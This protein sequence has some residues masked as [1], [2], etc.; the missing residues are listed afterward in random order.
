MGLSA[1]PD[2]GDNGIHASA[3]PFEGLAERLNW[4][5]AQLETDTFGK[6][7]LAAGVPTETIM[8]YTQ[9]PQVSFDGEMTSLFDLLED[10]DADEC[11]EKAAKAEMPE[12]VKT[13]APA[14]VKAPAPAVEAAEEA[15]A[16]APA[17]VPVPAAAAAE[18][19]SSS[20]AGSGT[21]SLEEITSSSLPED[22]DSANKELSLH[23][24]KFQELFGM[25][26]EAFQKLPQWKR[27]NL[28][29][30]HGLF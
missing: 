18:S 16:P 30:K 14:V 13:P 1:Q 28:K 26:K 3:S 8:A 20:G 12:V 24:D 10:T 5:G 29:K 6:K 19:S 9:D 4:C 2:T 15:P 22:V 11:C 25:D 27:G 17:E 7:L 23:D 21:Y